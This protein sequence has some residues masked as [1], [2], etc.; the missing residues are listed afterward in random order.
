MRRH[1][2]VVLALCDG[3]AWLLAMAT[4]S[5]LRASVGAPG[6][7]TPW[8]GALALGLIAAVLQVSFG[9]VVR[10]HH[11][12]AAVG[13]F[14]EMILLGGVTVSVGLV[15]AVL[16]ALLSPPLVPRTVPVGA[17]FMAMALVAWLRATWRRLHEHE[18]RTAERTDGMTPVLIFGAGDG[19]RQLVDSMLRDPSAGWWPV[20]LLDD[21]L[22]LR[23]RRVR[24]IP[25]LGTGEDL[26]RAVAETG[27][28]TL[29]VAIPSASAELLRTMERRAASLNID[30]KVLPSLGEL[31]DRRVAVS[32]IRDLQMSDL[33]GRHQIDTDVASVADYLTGRVVLVTGAGGSIG[34]ELCRQIWRY[35]PA[36]LLMLDR[37]ESALHAVQLSIHGRAMLDSPD[38]VLADIRDTERIL[39]VFEER[40]PDVVFHA[41]ALKHLSMLEQ[42]PAEAVR[43]NVWGTH[44]VLEAAKR[45]G[46]SRFVNIS[47]DKAANPCSVL[48]YTKRLA[49][50]LTATVAREAS[51]T[52]LSVRFGNVLGSRG[53]VLTAFTSQIEAGGPVTVTDPK[54]TR[55]FMTVQEAVQLVIQ[56]AAIGRDG[57]ALVLDMGK[58]VSIDDVARN[59]IDMSGKQIEVVYTG[60]REGEKLHEELFGDGEPD[61]RPV[62]PLVSHI[63][64]PAVRPAD[65]Y[66]VDLWS[67]RGQVTDALRDI[68]AHMVGE[69]A[70]QPVRSPRSGQPGRPRQSESEE[71]PT[72]RR[73]RT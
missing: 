58:P 4:F 5:V 21:R 57:E 8:M 29:V 38:L 41:A 55:Y 10:L 36:E 56:A 73:S 52:F 23:H 64:V 3:V 11:G 54:V 48:G 33:L 32:D 44:A 60:L 51:G 6:G 20:G 65:V 1:R 47:T 43:T 68:C 46:V 22:N 49:E 63:S 18:Y 39:Q 15:A 53:S 70:H 7:V 45:T 67:R 50:G 42:Y 59:L 71:L 13:S 2:L 14:E 30:L 66:S 28:R 19:G 31:L 40:R 34:S 72:W 16:N 26:P 27:C 69:V 17:S 61:H 35:A 37:D 25:V 24:G 12:R 9:W 62:H